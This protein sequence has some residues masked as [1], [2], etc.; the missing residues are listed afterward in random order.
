MEWG[1]GYTPWAASASWRRRWKKAPR[2]WSPQRC[3]GKWISSKLIREILCNVERE[4]KPVHL[5]LFDPYK[6]RGYEM[7]TGSRLRKL[8]YIVTT[9]TVY[10]FG[11]A[12][13]KAKAPSWRSMRAVWLKY[14]QMWTCKVNRIK[15]LIVANNSNGTY[16]HSVW[17]EAAPVRIG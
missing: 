12:L 11:D 4:T 7:S 6:S 2:R 3:H 16:K 15:W 14:R 5:C 13:T 1:K 9:A 17:Y 8:T 10:S